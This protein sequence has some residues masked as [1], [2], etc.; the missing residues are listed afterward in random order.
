MPVVT[1]DAGHTTSSAWCIYDGH[2]I[3]VGHVY[4]GCCFRDLT[5]GLNAWEWGIAS[6][7][8]SMEENI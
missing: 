4:E 7:L 8:Q 1:P 3:P 6:V 2:Y 5:Q